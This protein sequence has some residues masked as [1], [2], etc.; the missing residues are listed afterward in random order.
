MIKFENLN[1]AKNTANFQN[2]IDENIYIVLNYLEE[3][4]T[5]KQKD[6]INDLKLSKRTIERIIFSLKEKGNLER[7]G[8]NRSGY[9]KILKK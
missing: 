2:K 8:N 4:P 1:T 7:V 9:W 5:A 6:V 3:Y